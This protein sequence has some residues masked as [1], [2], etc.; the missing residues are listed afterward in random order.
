MNAS[1]RLGSIPLLVAGRTWTVDDGVAF[2]ALRGDLDRP[3]RDTLTLIA[4]EETA[5]EEGL[6]HSGESL[7][8]ASEKF[9][10]AHDLISAGETEAWLSA[11]G[12][13][14]DDFGAWLYQRL[15]ME[16]VAIAEQTEP[17]EPPHDFADL[18]RVHLWL[19][20]EMDII[21][22][23]LRRRVAAARELAEREDHA[24][25]SDT[26][27]LLRKRTDT[28]VLQD[29]GRDRE[30]LEEIARMD[31]AF[32]RLSSGAVTLE[33]RA[34]KLA[35]RQRLLTLLEFDVLDVDSRDAAREAALCVH[36]DHVALTEVARAAGFR[37]LRRQV[38]VED[39]D[40]AIAER[41]LGAAEGDVIEA[42]ETEGRFRIYHLLGKHPP[43]LAD[44]EVVHRIDRLL[45]DELF[46]DLVARHIEQ[47]APGTP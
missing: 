41:L 31:S 27:A 4:A 20:G 21:A 39:L 35:T 25:I 40:V 33:A 44:A 11:R 14:M 19:S 30:W 32:E 47:Q 17:I 10:Y 9:R 28:N 36:E 43:S 26:V 5:G 12:L 8:A 29:I 37:V 42:P 13:T 3:V 45:L 2:A 24:S 16:R 6:E 22:Q 23:G 15:C 7:Q 1:E 46:T 34:R 38:F 18:L